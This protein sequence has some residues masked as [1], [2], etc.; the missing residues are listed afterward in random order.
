MMH[1]YAICLLRWVIMQA[2]SGESLLKSIVEWQP[3]FFLLVVQV[4]K[5]ARPV[6]S[7]VGRSAVLDQTDFR[8]PRVSKRLFLFSIRQPCASVWSVSHSYAKPDAWFMKDQQKEMV[9]C[10]FEFAVCAH[11]KKACARECTLSRQGR[12]A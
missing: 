5:L 1:I 8:G 7:I 3:T 11:D 4:A 6:R 12:A 9:L 10:N 2:D